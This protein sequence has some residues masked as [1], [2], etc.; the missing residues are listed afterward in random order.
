MTQLPSKALPRIGRRSGTGAGNGEIIDAS[1]PTPG[2]GNS[3]YF[4]K[5][6]AGGDP[7][8]LYAMEPEDL[9]YPLTL[10]GQGPDHANANSY[11]LYLFKRLREDAFR[12]EEPTGIYGV[13]ND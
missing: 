10:Q 7:A 8:R 4:N 13:K 2:G 1:Y 9:P 5:E 6:R 12:P 3:E 11:A